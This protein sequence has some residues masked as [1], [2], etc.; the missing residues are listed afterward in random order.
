MQLKSIITIVLLGIAAL[1]QACAVVPR[2]V[3]GHGEIVVRSG[4]PHHYPS[5]P[6]YGRGY[7][8]P[9]KNIRVQ[10]RED[11]HG[12]VSFSVSESGLTE[13]QVDWLLQQIDDHKARCLNGGEMKRFDR[14]SNVRADPFS[15]VRAGRGDTTLRVEYVCSRSGERSSSQSH[16]SKPPPV[17]IPRAR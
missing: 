10:T 8:S 16:S 12:L 4:G 6:V 7:E 17:S 5:Y 13:P 2:P 3:Y 14:T 9:W 11:E 1:L 15:S